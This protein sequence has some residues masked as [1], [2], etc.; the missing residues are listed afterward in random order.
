MTEQDTPPSPDADAESLPRH[1]TPTWE[2]E[3]LISGAAVFAM[4]QLP[5]WLG[6]T[7]LP[8]MP[9]FVANLGS[10]FVLLYGYLAGAAIILAITFALHLLLRAHWIALV[11]L[12]SVFPDGV[13][14][15]KL[16]IG[17]VLRE[18][19][20]RRDK[21]AAVSIERADNRA[22]MVFALGVMLATLMLA[23][24]IVV[25]VALAI[26]AAI[27]MFGGYGAN[28]IHVFLALGVLIG[29]PIGMAIIVDRLLGKKLREES[30]LRRLLN[31]VYKIYARLGIVRGFSTG[32]L[33][34]SHIGSR[35]FQWLT[36]AI[37]LP[38]ILGVI[39]SFTI[40]NSPLRF[41]NYALFPHFSPQNPHVVAA[42]HYDDRR[43]PTS[44]PAE[45]Y[46]QSVV[47]AGPYL[48][49]IVPYPPT[50]D[51]AALR[52]GCSAVR[53]AHRDDAHAVAMLDCLAAL[54]PVSLD[55]KPLAGLHYDVTTDPRTR[56][57]ALQAMIDMRA[58][59]PGRHVLLVSRAPKPPS[60]LN[61]DDKATAW[62]I[63]FWR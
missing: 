27:R 35:R 25:L 24:G 18:F 39:V 48:R 9:R 50:R 51:D 7:L 44:D 8:L 26:T 43:D 28:V 45:P 19:S 10:A 21:G 15:E 49:L 36:I 60:D 63:P 30:V 57:P 40:G 58:L 41:G 2:V 29:F 42:T 53:T 34:E 59:T 22:T 52:H 3:M 4:L 20:Q 23:L 13:R 32:S 46:I 6:E 14:W 31:R 38:V 16:R 61:R 33:L 11:G 55:G 54:H 12:H 5:G 62:A 17:R 1:T 56:R 47:I 37:I